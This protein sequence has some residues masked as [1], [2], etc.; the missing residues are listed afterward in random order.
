VASANS[1]AATGASV[2]GGTKLWAARYRGQ[3]KSNIP[4]AIVASPDGTTVFVTGLSGE[5]RAHFSTVAYNAATGARRWAA[6]FYGRGYTQPYAIAVSPDGSKLFV[7]GFTSPVSIASER[8]VTVA[9]AAA[10]GAVLWSRT[11]PSPAT[12]TA[13]ASGASAAGVSPDGTLVFMT[14]ISPGTRPKS[15]NYATIA[16]DAA[17]GHASWIARYRG[18]QDFAVASALAVSPAGQAVFV[19][20]YLHGHAGSLIFR[21][22]AYQP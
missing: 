3:A 7:T 10:S 11:Y 4:M 6:P 18:R 15:S 19:T 13:G 17:T 14:G 9:Y 21:T 1:S 5:V 22:V 2:P 12:S 16:Y 8:A 20:G